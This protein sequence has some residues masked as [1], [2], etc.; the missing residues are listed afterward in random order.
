MLNFSRKLHRL[1][2]LLLP[3][4]LFL[5]CQST[6][7]ATTPHPTP[8]ARLESIPTGAVKGSP[9]TDFWPPTIVAG[10]SKPVPLDLPVNTAG[11]ED[12]AFITPD[13]NTLY[14]FF[15]PDV[16][17]PVEKTILD[18]LTGIWMSQR[19]GER[20]SDPVRVRLTQPG[21]SA[22]DGCEMVIGDR[23][24]FCSVR[25]GNAKTIQWY[26]AT[27]QAGAWSNW[28]DAGQW[29]NQNVDGEMHITT[30][31]RD[32]YFASKRAGGQGGFDLWVS[33]STPDGWGEPENLGP[34]VNTAADENRPFVSYDG[35]ELWFDSVSRQGKPGPATFRCLRQSDGTWVACREMI[36]SF[37][38]EPNL[39][40]DGKT[41]YFIHH[42]YSADMQKMIEAD[43]YVA[44]RE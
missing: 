11:G 4:F 21:Q 36:G 40:G 3:G 5:A 29:M 37:A 30:G 24:Y 22:L 44:Y 6:T 18:G 31:Y 32:I 12:S 26:Y 8:K 28:T 16:S 15:T 19:S 25:A 13:G 2:P 35:Q 10:W 14:F 39:T 1:F 38:G 9:D 23:M 43:I 42:F 34:Q 27:L 41:L 33:R 17:I 7:P 20:W